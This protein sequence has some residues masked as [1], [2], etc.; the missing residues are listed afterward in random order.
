[1][2]TSNYEQDFST[3]KGQ[4][5]SIQDLLDDKPSLRGRLDR[6]IPKAYHPA[7]LVPVKETDLSEATPPSTFNLD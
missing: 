1:M 4:G 7:W 2:I 6:Q 5:L 3:T